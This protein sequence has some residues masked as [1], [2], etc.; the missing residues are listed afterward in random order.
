M[1]LF[2]LASS[3]D[4][5]ARAALVCA[6]QMLDKIDRLN[7]Q[8]SSELAEPLAMGIG[9]HTGPVIVGLMGPPKTPILTALGDAVNTA[10]RLESATKEFD[11]PVV[12][13]RA[14][15]DAARLSVE[16]PCQELMLRGRSSELSVYA[17]GREDLSQLV[18]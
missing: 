3:S 9:I 11:D 7:R 6:W 5:G 10:A 2:G 18:G 15:L 16:R 8:M 14:T 13:S 4:H 17:L 1:A 12:V